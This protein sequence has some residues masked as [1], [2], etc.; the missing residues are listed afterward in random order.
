MNLMESLRCAGNG[1]CPHFLQSGRAQP[2][3]GKWGLSPTL[4]A[5]AV[6][7]LFAV[8]G[9]GERDS[10]EAQVR[11]TIAAMETAAEARSVGDLTEHI[12]PEFRDAS[13]R[14]AKELS[15]YV[16]GYFIANQS[17]HL[18]T[19][20]ESIEFPTAEEARADV[21]V[22]MVGL[23]AEAANAWDMAGEIRK[24]DVTLMREEGEWKVTRA[25]W[26]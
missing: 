14:D 10:A 2:N 26:Q 18:L 23:D 1:D 7:V 19:R 13:G 8:A 9:C 16:R 24:F 3:S 5:V 20:I 11:A 21:T 17:I 22:A 6:L 15:Q 4:F 25:K 12:S